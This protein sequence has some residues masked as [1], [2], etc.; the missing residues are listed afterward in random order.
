M[1]FYVLLLLCAAT[2]VSIILAVVAM[3]GRSKG[4]EGRAE[5]ERDVLEDGTDK[6]KEAEDAAAEERKR[7]EK[8]LG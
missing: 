2:A 5:A 6:R 1:N 3:F 7:L 8:E 4:N